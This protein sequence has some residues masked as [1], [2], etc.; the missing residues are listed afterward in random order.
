MVRIAQQ[1]YRYT[2]RLCYALHDLNYRTGVRVYKNLVHILT[3]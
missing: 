3:L 1:R 2:M